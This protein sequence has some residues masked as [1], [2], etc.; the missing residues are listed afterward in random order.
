MNIDTRDQFIGVVTNNKTFEREFI[1]G[2]LLVNSTKSNS[3]ISFVSGLDNEQISYLESYIEYFGYKM[4]GID[5]WSDLKAKVNEK[6]RQINKELERLRWERWNAWYNRLIRNLKMILLWVICIPFLLLFVVLDVVSYVPV[7]ILRFLGRI[8][9]RTK[10]SNTF[11]TNNNMTNHIV[12]SEGASGNVANQVINCIISGETNEE[13][14]KLTDNTKIGL[15][16]KLAKYILL[17]NFEKFN[18]KVV[19]FLFN[20]GVKIKHVPYLNDTLKFKLIVFLSFI[21]ILYLTSN[22]T[23]KLI[24]LTLI[25]MLTSFITSVTQKAYN[26]ILKSDESTQDISAQLTPDVVSMP[27]TIDSINIENEDRDDSVETTSDESIKKQFSPIF[28]YKDYYNQIQ[29]AFGDR[30][31]CLPLAEMGTKQI[32]FIQVQDMIDHTKQNYYVDRPDGL[33]YLHVVV[34]RTIQQAAFQVH[35]INLNT[36]FDPKILPVISDEGDIL[37]AVTIRSNKG[38]EIDD[39]CGF[40]NDWFLYCNELEKEKLKKEIGVYYNG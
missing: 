36:K 30:N 18:S 35:Y 12:I 11:V 16:D 23:V 9:R 33:Y 5:S 25:I 1:L 8:Q 40:K 4:N 22:T 26:R 27:P 28:T 29:K 6:V 14:T 31:S 7:A 39:L 37:Y 13:K 15:A 10:K 17:C 19:T 32:E 34:Y 2:S 21:I 3:S 20:L 38:I 24:A